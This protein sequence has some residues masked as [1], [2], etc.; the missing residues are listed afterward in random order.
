MAVSRPSPSFLVDDLVR[1][2]FQGRPP[3]RPRQDSN[4]RTR[5]RRPIRSRTG[6]PSVLPRAGRAVYRR[7]V[8]AGPRTMARRVLVA[9]ERL[10]HRVDP[11][12]VT[13]PVTAPMGTFK[14]PLRLG[15]WVQRVGW[16]GRG[17]GLTSVPARADPVGRGACGTRWDERQRRSAQE[18]CPESS[19]QV[20]C[21]GRS[22]VQALD[23]VHTVEVVGSSPASPTGNALVDCMKVSLRRTL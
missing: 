14:P 23:Q 5:H 12:R 8:R 15:P 2:H 20:L 3:C 4:M 9:T 6:G 21:V 13:E 19:Q 11:G 1:C 17:G 22:R 18:P 10:P 7:P 16:S